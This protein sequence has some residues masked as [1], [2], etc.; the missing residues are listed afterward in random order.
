[1][2][3]AA[4]AL[5]AITNRLATAFLPELQTFRR[6]LLRW[7]NQILAYFDTG[8]TNGRTEGFNSK[9]KLVKKRAYGYKE[10]SKLQTQTPKRVRLN[11]FSARP[12]V[13]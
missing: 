7:R 6:T 9:A 12:T 4:A 10:L 5:T 1:M 13:E 11:S 8:L 3:R 2:P